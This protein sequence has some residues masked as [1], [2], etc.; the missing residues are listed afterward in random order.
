MSLKGSTT[1]TRYKDDDK[2]K[3]D[4][5]DDKDRGDDDD[6]ECKD[7][8]KGD[9]DD[10]DKGDDDDDDDRPKE[11]PDE[12]KELL[13]KL[14][15]CPEDWKKDRDAAGRSSDLAGTEV[16]LLTEK[17]LAVTAFP[18]PARAGGTTL[19][20]NIP[21]RLEGER[22]R[23]SLFDVS[24][25]LVRNLADKAYPAGTHTITW[26]L[27]DESGVQ[28]SNGMYFYRLEVG[29]DHLTQRLMVLP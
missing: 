24:G 7:K 12:D 19:Q 10:D 9:D 6:D 26:N 3:G 17:P 2:D 15:L 20:F 11:C 23:I 14:G 4:D 1:G 27:T 13:K 21:G 5:D 22:V 18:N 16:G 28:V 8:D 25:R 29:G